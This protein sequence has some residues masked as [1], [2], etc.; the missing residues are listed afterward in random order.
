MPCEVL[1]LTRDNGPHLLFAFHVNSAINQS[2]YLWY[3]SGLDALEQLHLS[4]W[5]PMALLGSRAWLSGVVDGKYPIVLYSSSSM[6][7]LV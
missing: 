6:L 1:T 2:A 5:K 3:K 4:W 7:N